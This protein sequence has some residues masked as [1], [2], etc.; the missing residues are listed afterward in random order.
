MKMVSEKLLQR[1]AILLERG[2][3][4]SIFIGILH[5]IV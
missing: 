1:R 2:A 5:K 4:K 3:R